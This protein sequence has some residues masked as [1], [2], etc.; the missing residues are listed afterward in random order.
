MSVARSW[1]N[2][3]AWARAYSSVCARDKVYGSCHEGFYLSVEVRSEVVPGYQLKVAPFCS[4]PLKCPRLVTISNDKL[5]IR[6]VEQ[7]A[8]PRTYRRPLRHT[9]KYGNLVNTR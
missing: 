4:T 1:T 9:D 3:K 5:P 7:L 8:H 6:S 2:R